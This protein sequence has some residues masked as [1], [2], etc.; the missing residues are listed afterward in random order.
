MYKKLEDIAETYDKPLSN[1]VTM[2]DVQTHKIMTRDY[3]FAKDD[4]ARIQS[5]AD[6]YHKSRI[7]SLEILIRYYK[8]N[9]V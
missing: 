3:L 9:G 1:V 7:A 8:I 5:S 2:W 4:L 6:A